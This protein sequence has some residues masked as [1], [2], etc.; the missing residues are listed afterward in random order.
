ME[1]GEKPKREFIFL[2][3]M[4]KR[5]FA[6]WFRVVAIILILFGLLYLF[7]GLKIFSGSITLL[8]RTMNPVPRAVLLDWVSALYAAIMLGWG[9]TLL[10]VGRIAFKRNDA[11]LKRALII[12]LAVWLAIEAAASLL[13]G[14]WINAGVDAAV[15]A[16]FSV[17]LLH[18]FRDKEPRT[19]ARELRGSTT[20]VH[21]GSIPS[22]GSRLAGSCP[23]SSWAARS[24]TR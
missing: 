11:E 5:Q 21:P 1:T 7:F 9:V 20:A 2:R 4:S 14:V 10:L 6:V 23:R 19:A 24:R 13:L 17:P 22:R 15:L 12:G 8:G 3:Q 16:L 18:R